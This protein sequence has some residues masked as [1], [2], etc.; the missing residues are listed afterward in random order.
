MC[1][2]EQQP[3]SDQESPVLKGSWLCLLLREGK[4]VSDHT[5]FVQARYFPSWRTAPSFCSL[6]CSACYRKPPSFPY[7]HKWWCSHPNYQGNPLLPSS[8]TSPLAAALS[9]LQVLLADGTGAS[10]A[11]WLFL[12]EEESDSPAGSRKRPN[13]GSMTNPSVGSIPKATIKIMLTQPA[14]LGQKGCWGWEEGCVIALTWIKYVPHTHCWAAQGAS[15]VPS[16]LCC[17]LR[18]RES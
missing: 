1:S 2:A 18:F 10:S 8:S 13:H 7:L 11:H 17:N 6:L 3:N 14:L 4:H 12:E 16:L 15:S 9:L 5:S